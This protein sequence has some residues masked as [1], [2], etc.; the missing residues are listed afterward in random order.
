[1]RALLWRLLG[2]RGEAIVLHFASGPESRVRAMYSEIRALEPDR[3]HLVVC[4]DEPIDGLPCVMARTPSAVRNSL[5]ARRVGLAPFLMGAHPLV[6]VALRVA[7]RRLLA[8]NEHGERHHLHW[9]SPIA[10][11]LFWRG[12]ALDRIWLRPAWWPWARERSRP[13]REVAELAGRPLEDRKRVAVVSP[14]YPWPLSHG[15]AVRIFNL[16]REASREF[17]IFLYCFS[18]PG[19]AANPG[20]VPEFI[21]RTVLYDMPRYREPRWASVVPPEVREFASPQLRERLRAD[22]LEFGFHLIQAEYT[23]LAPYT[24]DVVVEH[25]VTFDLYAQIRS[26][27]GGCGAWWNWWRWRRFEMAAA[28]RVRRVIVMAEKDREQLPVSGVRILPNG[29]DLARFSPSP[30]APGLRLLFIGSVRHFPNL[31]AVRFL[32]DSIWPLVRAAR[33]DAELTIVAGPDHTAYWTDCP[34]SSAGLT[35]LGFVAGVEDLYRACTLVLSPT[36]VSAGTNLKVLEAMAMERAVVATPSGC[37]GLGLQD[38]ESAWIAEDAVAFTEGVLTLGADS[39]LRRRLAVAA[40]QLAEERF[41]W[42]AI[43]RAQAELW[44][45]L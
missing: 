12:V 42:K 1:M 27:S 18:E 17:D 35:I 33:P 19:A 38:R 32:L 34:S 3:E 4:W 15:G 10:S 23:Q 44:N 29:V 8:F 21:H 5:G 40:R 45:E 39:D 7:P 43:G 28:R 37:A 6:H 36:L 9:T 2:K 25:D 20:P 26:R 13:G 22:S 30:E 41:D 11:W 14:Y 24:N 16:L 31:L